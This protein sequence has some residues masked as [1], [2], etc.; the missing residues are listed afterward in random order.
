[1]DLNPVV[2]GLRGIE[3]I[4]VDTSPKIWDF[5]KDLPLI[6]GTVIFLLLL[7]TFA[8][9]DAHGI[10]K[11]SY[12]L[13]WLVVKLHFFQRKVLGILYALK[14]MVVFY[15]KIYVLIKRL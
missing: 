10:I 2:S 9:M 11:G 7:Y 1:M 12:K 5:K 6:Q 3:T 4:K 14:E 8:K 15:F 13:F